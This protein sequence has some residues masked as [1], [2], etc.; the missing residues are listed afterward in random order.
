MG[1]TTTD[2]VKWDDNMGN[3]ITRISTDPYMV[4]NDFEN[5][6]QDRQVTSTLTIYNVNSQH[7]G[8]Y[9]FVLSLNYGD[10]MSRET[11]LTVLTGAKLNFNGQ[12][13]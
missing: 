3:V 10:V 7:A 4:L 11:S 9:Q 6:G 5:V 8:L 12:N 1:G 13:P 2:D